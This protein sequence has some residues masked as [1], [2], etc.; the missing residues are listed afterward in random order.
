[1]IKISA[2][3]FSIV[4]SLLICGSIL[5]LALTFGY[6]KI[7]RK[8]PLVILEK[9]YQKRKSV[10]FFFYLFG[11]SGFFLVFASI[12]IGQVE[13]MNG[14]LIFSEC[15]KLCGIIYGV[16]LFT[17]ITRYTKLFPQIS[18]W[19]S[20]HSMSDQ[21]AARLF[22]S[23]NIYIGETVT[24]HIAFIFLSAMI[25]CSS[26]STILSGCIASWIGSSGILIA[27]GLMIG[28]LEFLGLKKAF[29]INRVFSSLGG[30]WLLVL[31]LGLLL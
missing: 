25:F 31:G 17:G 24:E 5:G 13:E 18:R 7:I 16:L 10:P 27:T 1:M 9:L 11:F 30:I 14:E 8:E 19:H 2:A 23:F 26:I 15:G 29:M 12:L 3:I 22:Q 4:S 28:N 6:P 20:E 21:G